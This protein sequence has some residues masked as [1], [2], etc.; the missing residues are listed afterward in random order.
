MRTSMLLFAAVCVAGLALIV[1]GCGDSGV[2]P[3]PPP[4]PV[5]FTNG[6]AASV[7]IGQA[8]FSG[9]L[10]NRGGAVADNTIN[11]SWAQGF[12]TSSGVLYLPDENNHRTLVY[13]TIPTTNGAS[14]N[15]AIGQPD[16]V[17]SASGV[18]ATA[19]EHPQ[20]LIISG[21]K[22]IQADLGNNRV[23]IYNT[24]PS[25]SPGTIDVVV[26]LPDK[27]SSTP[28]CDASTLYL[29]G[30]VAVAG[31]KLIVT[32]SGN[33]R[34]LIWNTI[35][36]T[37]GVA[38]NIVLGQ[39][40]FTSCNINGASGT[41]GASTLHLPVGM[42]S[43]GT[44]LVIA[45]QQNNRVL[46]WNTIPTSNAQPADL[47]LGQADFTHNDGNRGGAASANTMSGPYGG[48]FFTSAQLFVGDGWNNRVLV[49]NTF[50]STNGQA[51]DVVLGQ[52]NFTTTISGTSSTVMGLPTGVFLFGK[53]L[54]VSDTGNNR[55]LI[56]DG[57]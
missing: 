13:N 3:P 1:V 33:N 53:Q 39:T 21:G 44:R 54:L 19:V 51:A 31:G 7:V 23:I 37:D 56:F 11:I 4:T 49:W 55:Y 38:A 15:F 42:W 35:P 40:D 17:S 57:S 26:G 47:V 22:L 25:S 30:S 52:P 32:D 2:V 27:I 16:L 12:V 50:P 41:V 20:Q 28:L 9:N 24:V 48:V 5:Q 29:P 43:D 46:I 10:A 6:Q 14:A 8:D 34:V 18:S 36:T 45:D